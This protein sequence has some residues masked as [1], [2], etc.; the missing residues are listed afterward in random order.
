MAARRT[1]QWPRAAFAT[2]LTRLHLQGAL[3]TLSVHPCLCLCAGEL[4]TQFPTSLSASRL[5]SAQP[6]VLVTSFL[7]AGSEASRTSLLHVTSGWRA[8]ARQH[9]VR[10]GRG[11]AH[12]AAARVGG[13]HHHGKCARFQPVL[14]RF[15]A[16]SNVPV[17][18]LATVVAAGR[19]QLW[20]TGHGRGFLCL[21]APDLSG[22]AA[23]GSL[24][25]AETPC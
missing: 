2:R 23:S 22:G 3:C 14:S 11:H 7:V 16:V 6:L 9:D 13:P 15:T 4:S 20:C 17:P 10:Q 24:W 8:A 12:Q 19:A 1:K 21:T 5:V 25:C 18:P